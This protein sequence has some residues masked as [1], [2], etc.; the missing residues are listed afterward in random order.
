MYARVNLPIVSCIRVA[1][2]AGFPV[3]NGAKV[4]FCC[5]SLNLILY[6]S[7]ALL[8]SSLVMLSIVSL[9]TFFPISWYSIFCSFSGCRLWNALKYS[10]MLHNIV[11]IVSIEGF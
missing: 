11:L 8:S 7:V 3:P 4:M 1:A 9:F 5:V 2:S 6:V 10:A